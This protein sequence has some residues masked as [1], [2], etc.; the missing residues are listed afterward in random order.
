[1]MNKT[2]Q[3]LEFENEINFMKK[4]K[5]RKS[6]KYD[7]PENILPKAKKALIDLEENH[8]NSF[9]IEM[10]LNNVKRLDNIN[11]IYRGNKI[12]GYEFWTNVYKYAKCIKGLGYKKGD[13]IPVIMSNSPEYFY[14]LT[15]IDI[16]GAKMNIV[17]PWF[18]KDYLKE[19]FINSQSKYIFT[20]D[21]INDSVMYGIE[22]ADNIE[23]I[24]MFSLTDSLPK[25]NNGEGFNPYE[26]IDKNFHHFENSIEF[27]KERI[28]KPI[29]TSSEFKKYENNYQG[30]VVEDMVLSDPCVITYTSGTTS[31]GR[32]KACIHSNRNYLSIARFKMSDV[33][34][35]P[36][37]KK[38][39]V[40]AHLPSYTQTVLTTAYTDPLYM[41]WTTVL[42]P[43]YDLEFYPYSLLINKPNYTCETPEYEKYV[44][45]VLDTDWKKVQMKDRIAVIIAGQELSPG[46]EKY[47]NKI[48]REHK[49]G[50]ARLPFPLAPVTVSIAGG[51]TENGGYLTTLFKGLQ[52]KKFKYLL[53]KEPMLLEPIG[54]A[55]MEVLR[56][57]GERCEKYERGMCVVNT[58]TNQIGYV[59]DEFNKGTTITDEFG[60]KWRT[61]NTPGYK[62]NFGCVR[63]VNRP[64]TDIITSDGRAIPLYTILDLVQLDTKNIME[65]CLVKVP[66]YGHEKYVI[67]IEKQ[68]NSRIDD[69]KLLIQIKGRLHNKVDSEVLDNMYFRFRTFEEGFPVAGTGKTDTITLEKE[70]INEKCVSYDDIH[71]QNDALTRV[72]KMNL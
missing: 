55:E 64:N 14:L 41:G 40:L 36:A 12:N 60:K 34:P 3:L 42:E 58:P 62:D 54:L 2:E 49:F 67:H 15:A 56:P 32:P 53:H 31:A 47:L 19:I 9:A 46:L 27:Y 70:G 18:D 24:V 33:S 26:E 66:D 71:V 50:M 59:N 20:T 17:G 16:I 52:E 25:D 30:H 5:C 23:K 63:F 8:D 11:I 43:Y 6:E 44:A 7:I 45:K 72:K 61:T 29:I 37:L 68:P 39:K 69:D 51:T 65:A 4:N 10:Y 38:L 28:K 1:M 35:M 21:D 48:S 22:N 57:N 13:E